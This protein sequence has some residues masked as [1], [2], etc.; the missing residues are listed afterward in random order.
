MP[1]TN[2][3]DGTRIATATGLERSA[4]V[5]LGLCAGLVLGVVGF[6]TAFS[7]FNTWDDEGYFLLAVRA[8][9]D[10][11][12]Q[13]ERIRGVFY[14]PV[15]FQFVTGFLALLHLPL[16]TAGARWLLLIAW[17]LACSALARLAWRMCGSLLAVA[18]VLALDFPIL[19]WFTN[20][21][22]HANSPI[23]I[24]LS[25]LP[26]ISSSKRST[27]PIRAA[28][29]GALC[30]AILLVKINAGLLVLLALATAFAPA[31]QRFMG[32]SLRVLLCLVLALCPFVLMWRLL[33]DPS[34]LDFALLAS[35]SLIP[36]GLRLFEPRETHSTA[37][38]RIAFLA[39][40]G[41]L[42]A[43]SLG[44]CLL[45]GTTV[46]GLWRGIFADG[47]K[48]LPL[49]HH[50]PPLPSRAAI[51]LSSGAIPLVSV[52][53]RQPFVRALM[54]LSASLVVLYLSLRLRAPLAAMPVLWL[55]ASGRRAPVLQDTLGLL[56]VLLCLQAYPIAGSQL[57]CFCLL[58]ALMGV[59]GCVEATRELRRR[60]GWI[61]RW[62]SNSAVVAGCI[63]LLALRNPIWSGIVQLQRGWKEKVPLALP[64]TGPLRLPELEVA[65]YRWI[66]ANLREECDTF[67]GMAGM[68][69]FY[70]WSGLAPPV[71]FYPH[72]WTL[73][74]DT[75]EKR[76]LFRALCAHARPG[77]LFN[78]AL[79]AFWMGNSP[80]HEP[81]LRLAT[82]SFEPVARVGDYQLWLPPADRPHRVLSVTALDADQELF[83]RHGAVRGFVLH[84]PALAGVRLARVVI[85]DTATGLDRLDSDAASKAARVVLVDEQDRELPRNP[86]AQAIDLSHRTDVLMFWPRVRFDGSA[87]DILV[88]AFDTQGRRAAELLFAVDRQRR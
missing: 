62:L 63:A 17:A 83:A 23:L 85:R 50:S 36:F 33:H 76:A 43:L 16:D 61:P 75:G 26:W 41:V 73:L 38:V 71:P 70:L 45:Y 9:Q 87:A 74:Y 86:S 72:H 15:Y 82:E 13:Y 57:G 46:E 88:R 2:A 5:G 55:V 69:S 39:G 53:R 31:G 40:L 56:T 11:G 47:W 51:L 49:N 19:A 12:G 14:G 34:V 81:A 18:L 25:L 78:R 60:P 52:A 24:F 6:W 80:R 58:S 29:C 3:G 30:A 64:G 27:G 84:F 8:F 7:K 68:H 59:V 20:E 22:L 4:W 79:V 35:I 42:I 10:G 32:L 77:L 37:R 21:P 65:R 1:S 44:Q 28:A 67:L 54:Q 66:V 48:F